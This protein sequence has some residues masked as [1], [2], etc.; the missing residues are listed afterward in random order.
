MGRMYVRRNLEKNEN[1]LYTEDIIF[2]VQNLKKSTKKG[3]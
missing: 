1:Y 3:S 2:Y